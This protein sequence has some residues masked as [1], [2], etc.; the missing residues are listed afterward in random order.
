MIDVAHLCKDYGDFRALD[1]VSFHI[2]Q[3]EVVGF[4]GPNGA[5]KTTTMRILAGYMPPTDGRA[6]VAGFDV[7]EESLEVRRRI[8]YLP[9]SVPLY[10]EMTV[11]A[12]L[13]YMADL[14]RV[15][16]RAG[17]VDRSMQACHIDD[18]AGDPI[19]KLS[20]G[21][22]Q[23]VGLAQAILHEPQVLIL[24]EP[25]IGLDPKQIIEVRELIREIGREH[26]VLL[27]THILPEVSQTCNRVLIINEGQ[28]VAEGTP[29]ELTA[30]LHGAPRVIVELRGAPGDAA[31][32]LEAVPGVLGVYR[33]DEGRY[34][35]ACTPAV[36]L[37]PQLARA[38]IER[39]WE[40]LEL[41]AAGMSLEDIF[42]E[43]TTHDAPTTGEAPEAI[44][45]EDVL[46]A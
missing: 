31:R 1:D 9:E 5:G 25:T 44:V 12:Y 33:Q 4:L 16:D 41:R 36:D 35:V 24:D 10:D 3:G 37:R 13:R 26:T 11:R 27:S 32:T 40:L 39:G 23:R 42:L 45:D 17:A 8:G 21:L 29:E 22:K 6:S 18:R 30:R 28:I 34:E 14:R 38:V 15:P 20:K 2:D 46:D 19:G 43:L 7:F